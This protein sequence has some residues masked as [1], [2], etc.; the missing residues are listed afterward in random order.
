M[1][2]VTITMPKTNSFN[3]DTI[4]VHPWPWSPKIKQKV[5][6]TSEEDMLA[7]SV[8]WYRLRKYRILNSITSLT[9][10]ALFKAVI[11]EDRVYANEIRKFYSQ[12]LMTLALIGNPMSKFRQDL[13]EYINQPT[14]GTVFTEELL[15]L[16]FRL[17]EFYEYDLELMSIKEK[18]NFTEQAT[19]VGRLHFT[20]RA[21]TLYPIKH[22][23]RTTRKAR[24]LEYWFHDDKGAYLIKIDNGNTCLPLW[25]RE[26]KKESMTL[27]LSGGYSS[28]DSFI[29]CR[30]STWGLP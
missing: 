9:D 30:V 10:D 20:D 7:L 3:L 2:N 4:S 29:Y 1:S 26:F 17:P 6:S 27:L 19:V 13:S 11:P 8:T 28:I 22:L 14:D 21:T 24:Q 5:I 23:T 18:W 16:I 12:K 15:P 25:E